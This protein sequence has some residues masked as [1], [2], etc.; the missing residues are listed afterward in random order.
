MKI[1]GQKHYGGSYIRNGEVLS[2]C[3][4]KDDNIKPEV[5]IVSILGYPILKIKPWKKAHYYK[6]NIHE[7]QKFKSIAE[8]KEA[9]EKAN[10]K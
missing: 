5:T 9:I 2:F 1:D 8:V 3:T 7:D 4:S 6:I 10:N